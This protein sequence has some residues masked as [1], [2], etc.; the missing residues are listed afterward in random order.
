MLDYAPDELVGESLYS[1]CHAED[2]VMLKKAHSDG[3]LGENYTLENGKV[4][5]FS[6]NFLHRTFLPRS[7]HQG[8]SSNLLLSNDVQEWRLR[9][10]S[11]LRHCRK[12]QQEQRGAE[13][14][15]CELLNNRTR[16]AQL[17][18]RSVP[19]GHH[20]EAGVNRLYEK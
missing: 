13:H 18:R 14:N 7:N 9:E 2:A 3:E 8:T 19:A 16:A 4:F 1:L 12:L 5:I 20:R 11:N 17:Y 6:L 15:L 10:D